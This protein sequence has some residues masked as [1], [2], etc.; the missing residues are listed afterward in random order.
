MKITP[1]SDQIKLYTDIVI[2][3]IIVF[4]GILGHKK[5]SV[6]NDSK[7][8]LLSRVILDKE[9]PQMFKRENCKS[10]YQGQVMARIVFFCGI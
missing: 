10:F 1:H 6:K 5:Q 8:R 2:L 4:K 3:T 7:Q 9:F